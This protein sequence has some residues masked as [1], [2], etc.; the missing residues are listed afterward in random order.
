[1]KLEP[2]TANR[3]HLVPQPRECFLH[4]ICGVLA[5]CCSAVV[6]VMYIK[7]LGWIYGCGSKLNERG[8]AGFGPCFHLPGFHFG[9]GFFEPQ[10]YLR[11]G[12]D[13]F[14]SLHAQRH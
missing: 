12:Y 10:P 9:T 13:P 3:G 7:Q 5:S 11:R 1:M 14:P 6:V 8:C 4:T 2:Q